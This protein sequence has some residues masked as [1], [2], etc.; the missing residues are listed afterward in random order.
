M[1]T[2]GTYFD[3]RAALSST[4]IV[5][6][7][8]FTQT[9]GKSDMIGETIVAT[10]FV[11]GGV[12]DVPPTEYVYENKYLVRQ[13]T[14]IGETPS[15]EEEET[16]PEEEVTT[17]KENTEIYEYNPN[18]SFYLEKNEFNVGEPIY[19]VS[20]ATSPSAET[21]DYDWLALV[22]WNAS[23]GTWAT[24]SARWYYAWPNAGIKID[25]AGIESSVQMGDSDPITAGRY[26]VV[27]VPDNA[28]LANVDIASCPSAEITVKDSGA[29]SAYNASAYVYNSTHSLYL[30]KTTF[31]Y[32][33][34]IPILSMSKKTTERDG[35]WVAILGWN[36]SSGTWTHSA[37]RWFYI[38]ENTDYDAY[39]GYNGAW[40]DILLGIGSGDGS[41]S[42]YVMP[43]IYRV[44]VLTN[45]QT[46]EEYRTATGDTDL[47]NLL[48]IDITVTSD[49]YVAP[50]DDEELVIPSFGSTDIWKG[51]GTGEGGGVNATL[52]ISM[53]K[54]VFKYGEEWTAVVQDMTASPFTNGTAWIAIAKK[55]TDGSYEEYRRFVVNGEMGK[56]ESYNTAAKIVEAND[57]SLTFPFDLLSAGDAEP[58]RLGAG[59]YVVVFAASS[60]IATVSEAVRVSSTVVVEVSVYDDLSA[61]DA[62]R[63]NLW[64]AK[65]EYDYREPISVVAADITTGTD[66]YVA[67]VRIGEDGKC[68]TVPVRS[69]YINP[70]LNYTLA[71]LLLGAKPS[72]SSGIS[73]DV[74]V[75]EYVVLILDSDTTL[76]SLILSNGVLNPNYQPQITISVEPI[77]EYSPSTANTSVIAAYD[78][79]VTVDDYRLDENQAM[80]GEFNI[81]NITD[82]DVTDEHRVGIYVN[83]D[84]KNVDV[85]EYPINMGVAV[86]I[87]GNVYHSV[88]VNNSWIYV[89]IGAYSQYKD[90][91]SIDGSF[92]LSGLVEGTYDITF[93]LVVVEKTAGI[94]IL[95]RRYGE[96]PFVVDATIVAAPNEFIL[97]IEAIDGNADA[98]HV[99]EG[100]DKA[101]TVDFSWVSDMVG[102][103]VECTVYKQGDELSKYVELN[104]GVS[105]E[106]S[107][108]TDVS[109]NISV[110]F[111]ENCGAGVYRI[112][113]CPAGRPDTASVYYYVYLV[114]D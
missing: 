79:Q 77:Y 57:Y 101:H 3:S 96:P 104:D 1:G 88:R 32:Q 82:L 12:P 103:D 41:T 54:T 14:V 68:E 46:V 89:D 37:T 50:D 18:N 73:T 112:V 80:L 93:D 60:D 109:G 66:S 94:N 15:D 87:G 49:V 63:F 86:T 40:F 69:Y 78:K 43:G 11:D 38:N 61:T 20:F 9:E 113:V 105:V 75:G 8:D 27:M 42:A 48:H 53:P 107:P 51:N 58:S 102:T 30:E 114:E 97:T 56:Y 71:D 2:S 34:P 111:A 91:D 28:D 92:V 4:D 25:L 6:S 10:F 100:V 85:P 36:E 84:N 76:E 19:T 16:T 62:V 35:D 29:E 90:V 65:K 70:D 59:N 95:N 64:V 72:S 26:L 7:V 108:A 74:T 110:T 67:L 55:H 23:T 81:S 44:A 5:L 45:D 39:S 13:V 17:E 99:M 24:T 22:R 83:I 98:K 52:T 106:F 47:N 21:I 31:T 33:E